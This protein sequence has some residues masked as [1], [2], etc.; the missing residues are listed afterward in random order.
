MC[1][2][3]RLIQAVG[4]LDLSGS[5]FLSKRASCPHGSGS[6]KSTK[7]VF[8]EMFEETLRKIREEL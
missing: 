3:D 7:K 2:A 4:R 5:P 1:E 6:G 8:P